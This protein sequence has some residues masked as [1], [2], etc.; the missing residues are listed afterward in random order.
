MTI[1]EGAYPTG[2]DVRIPKHSLTKRTEKRLVLGILR[3]NYDLSEIFLMTHGWRTRY[4]AS[5][6][7]GTGDG[8]VVISRG[9]H[10]CVCVHIHLNV[11][12]YESASCSTC[13]CVYAHTTMFAHVNACIYACMYG[14]CVTVCVCVCVCV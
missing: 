8:R 9:L 14:V 4:G 3:K 13:K 1:L 10:V 2:S 11:W 6:G 5:G 12:A 7:C